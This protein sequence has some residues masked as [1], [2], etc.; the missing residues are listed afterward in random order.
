MSA[1]EVL[2]HEET[3]ALIKLSNSG[4]EE[5]LDKLVRHNIALVHSVARKYKDRGVDYD[6]LFQT[7]CIGLVKAVRNYNAEYGVRFS[8]Y[9]V[10]MILGEIKR[11]LRD[12]GMIRVSRT[13]KELGT[14]AMAAYESL[15]NRLGSDVSVEEVA[16]ELGEDVYDVVQSLEAMRPHISIYE[17]LYDDEPNALIADRLTDCVNTEDAVIN[18]IFLKEVIGSLGQRDRQIIN[19]R[20]FRNMTQSQTARVLGISQVQV[21][22]LETSIIKRLREQYRQIT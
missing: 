12:D 3:L 5:A 2:T 11:S 17:P 10:P 19:M 13:M 4:D 16:A 14:R 18:D 6:D 15:Q 20:Y 22:R 7:G 9:A 1:P 8:T 21:S